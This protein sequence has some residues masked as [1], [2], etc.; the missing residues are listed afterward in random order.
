MIGS[1]WLGWPLTMGAG[2]PPPDLQG[3]LG[4][5]CPGLTG[6]P[7]AAG[8]LGL[9]PNCLMSVLQGKEEAM[10][11]CMFLYLSHVI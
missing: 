3:A 1:T 9:K 2:W 10:K 6:G 11:R 4:L 5:G 8:P 7:P